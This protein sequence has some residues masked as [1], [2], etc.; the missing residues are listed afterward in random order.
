MPPKSGVMST[1]PSLEYLIP[2][3]T[4]LRAAAMNASKTASFCL[5]VGD[6]DMGEI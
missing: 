4:K 6:A 3:A 1:A 2:T 5:L